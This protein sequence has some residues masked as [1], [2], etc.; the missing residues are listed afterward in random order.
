[1]RSVAI[2]SLTPGMI[3]ARSIINDDMIVVLSEGTMLT[4]AHITRLGFLGIPSAYIKDEYELSEA[5][6]NVSAIF[7]PASAFVTEYKEV[8]HT[9][10]EIFDEAEK[11][12]KPPV[13]KSKTM[14]K[15]T[16][17]PMA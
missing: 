17:A 13:Q 2:E 7:N 16:L 14:V 11:S 5:F 9:A 10:R 1:M 4:K 12:N 8:I 6:Q 3:L 15:K